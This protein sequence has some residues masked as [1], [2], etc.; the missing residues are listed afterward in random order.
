VRFAAQLSKISLISSEEKVYDADRDNLGNLFASAA[1][2]SH[3]A[4]STS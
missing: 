1:E 3:A 4:D 2:T